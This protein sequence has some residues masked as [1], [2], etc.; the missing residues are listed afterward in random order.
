MSEQQQRTSKPI[1]TA[2]S[3]NGTTT[4]RGF[5]IEHYQDL[6]DLNNPV[7]FVSIF[8]GKKSSSLIHA[9][10]QNEWSDCDCLDDC[11]GFLGCTMT[12]HENEIVRDIFHAFETADMI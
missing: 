7:H 2:H 4:H 1:I 8:R 9:Y 6:S 12:L 5:T 11:S 3:F 10:N